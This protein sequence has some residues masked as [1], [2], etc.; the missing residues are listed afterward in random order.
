MKVRIK[1]M[2]VFVKFGTEHMETM[3]MAC[4]GAFEISEKSFS[5]KQELKKNQKQNELIHFWP[6]FPFYIP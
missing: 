2:D 4:I 1:K 5:A 3:T 6:I